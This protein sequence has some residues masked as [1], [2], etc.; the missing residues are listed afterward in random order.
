MEQRVD[1]DSWLR[2]AQQPTYLSRSAQFSSGK[3]EPLLISTKNTEDYTYHQSYWQNI[4]L[5]L[6]SLSHMQHKLA[7]QKR[8]K[9]ICVK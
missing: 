6:E 7:F 1:S 2:R 9:I 8:A 4:Q 5:T 3:Q